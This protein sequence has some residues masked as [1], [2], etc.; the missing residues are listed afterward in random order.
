M[1]PTSPGMP[2]MF[3]TAEPQ[4]DLPGN[5][6]VKCQVSG[7]LWEMVEEMTGGRCWQGLPSQSPVLMQ[8]LV[9]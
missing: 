4:Q 5:R 2:V 7:H 1:E 9:L 6:H 8:T 3:D